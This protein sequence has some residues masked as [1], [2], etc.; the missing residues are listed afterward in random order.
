M[1]RIVTVNNQ[2]IAEAA[3]II[4][5]GGLVGM[6]TETV[7]GLAGNARDGAAV[8][9]IYEAKGRP[10]FNPLIVHVPSA[11]AAAEI[12]EMDDRARNLASAFWPGPLTLVLARRA[13]A[14]ISELATAG[15][16]TVAVRVPD[17]KIARALITAAGVPLVAPSANKSG[18]LSPTTPSHVADGLGDGANMIL[19]DGACRVGLESTVVDLSGDVPF[20]LRPGAITAE[21]VSRVLGVDVALA[22]EN[23][24]NPKSPGMLL[25]HYAPDAPVRLNAIDLEA[26]EALLAFG[27]IKFMGVKGGGAAADLPETQIRNLSEDGDLHEA[28]ANLFAMLKDLDRAEHSKIAVMTVPENGLGVAINDRLRRAAQAG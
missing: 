10:A 5:S 21:E 20:I 28:A 6:P 13:D 19:A 17:H 23:D 26:G 18:S 14:G 24:V 15:L 7:Y 12:A 4:K 8:A 9:K 27:S 3:E 1:S 25:K 22:S 2:A 11:A 16:D